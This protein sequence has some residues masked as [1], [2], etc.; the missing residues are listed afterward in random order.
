MS[1]YAH[2]DFERYI[3]L[4]RDQPP[5]VALIPA[6]LWDACERSD[7]GWFQDLVASGRYV[8]VEPST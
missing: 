2:P 1:D 5:P 3:A 8:R 6:W 7:Q 4:L